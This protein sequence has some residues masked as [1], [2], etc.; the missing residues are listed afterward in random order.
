MKVSYWS[1]K[2]WSQPTVMIF[3]HWPRICKKEH[4][5]NSTRKL[6]VMGLWVKLF[7]FNFISLKEN[8]KKANLAECCLTPFLSFSS[9]LDYPL[10]ILCQC[11]TAF[12]KLI[13]LLKLVCSSEF[14][15]V[16]RFSSATSPGKN[17]TSTKTTTTTKVV[18]GKKIV[19][20]KTEDS[21]KVSSFFFF[22]NSWGRTKNI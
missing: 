6:I 15:T 1:G 11:K 14:S 9:V 7:V 17:V 19:T 3:K 4:K 8:L 12:L 22:R 21:D 16:I 10:R 13:D 20:K 2:D 18:D 5:K